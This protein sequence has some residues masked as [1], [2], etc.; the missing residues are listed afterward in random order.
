MFNYPNQEKKLWHRPLTNQGHHFLPR[1]DFL[2]RRY[3][4]YH[5]SDTLLT[6]MKPIFLRMIR[7]LSLPSVG[8]KHYKCTECDKSFINKDTLSKHMSAHLEER[9]FKCGKCGKLFKRLSHVREHIKIHAGSRPFPCTVCEKSFKTSVGLPLVF[10]KPLA[11]KQEG[12][13]RNVFLLSVC[14]SIV[15]TFVSIPYL[16][17]QIFMKY[18]QNVKSIETM[19]KRSW[20][21]Q[22]GWG[23]RSYL[24]IKYFSLHFHVPS[25]SIIPIEGFNDSCMY[26]NIRSFCKFLA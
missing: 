26:V 7:D 14:Q 6:C 4:K 24:K 21:S 25:I 15:I 16:L 2:R 17:W 1:Q 11:A 12:Y 9:N 19:N 22:A 8:V 10:V 5:K 23:Q 3:K 20:V 18:S 13:Y